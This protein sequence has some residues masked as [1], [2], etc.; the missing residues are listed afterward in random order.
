MSDHQKFLAR[1]ARDCEIA[2][3]NA[4]P[5]RDARAGGAAPAIL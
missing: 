2:L 1:L 5:D 4:A 3:P